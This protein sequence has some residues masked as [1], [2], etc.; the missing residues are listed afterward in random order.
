MTTTR[1]FARRIGLSA[2]CLGV[3]LVAPDVAAGQAST[4]EVTQQSAGVQMRTVAQ[5]LGTKLSVGQRDE[6]TLGVTLNG[7]L[8]EPEKLEKF[9]ITGVHKGA[10]VTAMRIA[11]QKVI[12]EVDEIDP[13]PFSR[14]ATL[15]VDDQGRLSAP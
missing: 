12:V 6:L 8:Q 2:V 4:T 11:P 9:G 10:R 5:Q 13:V 3:L 7:T 15:R 1:P 14:K